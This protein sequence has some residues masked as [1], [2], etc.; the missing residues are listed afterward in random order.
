M[1]ICVEID[2]SVAMGNIAQLVVVDLLMLT[3]LLT[4]F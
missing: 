3:H 4:I 1:Y 2:Y